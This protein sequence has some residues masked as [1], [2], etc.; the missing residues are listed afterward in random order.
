MTIELNI[1]MAVLNKVDFSVP[2]L[3]KE[4]IKK[5][6]HMKQTTYKKYRNEFME[7]ISGKIYPYL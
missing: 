7:K 4:E 2:Y 1:D 6:F 5:F 3:T